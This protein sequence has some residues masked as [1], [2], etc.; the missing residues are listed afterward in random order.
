MHLDETWA[1]SGLVG[2]VVARIGTIPQAD[3]SAQHRSFPEKRLNAFA[4]VGW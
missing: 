4:V 1:F 2:S 3:G